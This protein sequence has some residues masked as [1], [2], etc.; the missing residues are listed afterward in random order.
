MGKK[1][2]VDYNLGCWGD[3]A[4]LVCIPTGHNILL[5]MFRYQ[6]R[7]A[8]GIEG[9]I[10]WDI[11]G[12]F[13]CPCCVAIQAHRQLKNDG[14]VSAPGSASALPAQQQMKTQ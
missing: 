1:M 5:T 11:L 13:C 2:N 4:L 12:S 9:N 14:L 7:E 10:L 3:V 8:S 6:F